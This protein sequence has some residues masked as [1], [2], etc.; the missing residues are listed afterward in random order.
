MPADGRCRRRRRGLSLP[1]LCAELKR[2]DFAQWARGK[3]GFP[4]LQKPLVDTSRVVHVLARQLLHQLVLAELAQADCTLAVGRDGCGC[5]GRDARRGSSRGRRDPRRVPRS[6]VRAFGIGWRGDHGGAIV[7]TAH[8][9]GWN[10]HHCRLD[11]GD[12]QLVAVRLK[13]GDAAPVVGTDHQEEEQNADNHPRH[14]DAAREAAQLPDRRHW[15]RRGRG[16]RNWRWHRRRWRNRVLAYARRDP[17]AGDVVPCATREHCSAILAL[18]TPPPSRLATLRVVDRGLAARVPLRETL[19][20]DGVSHP[21]EPRC[22]Q[23]QWQ[24]RECFQ[25]CAHGEADWQR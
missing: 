11:H 14:A 4:L 19:V 16:W 1:G 8:R 3:R 20:L 17:R 21:S 5:R 13:A 6:T 23:E 15:R 22:A 7:A 2:D 18:T 12:L 9:R 10:P 24:E 25:G